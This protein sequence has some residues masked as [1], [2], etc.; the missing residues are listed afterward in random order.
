MRITPQEIQSRLIATRPE[1]DCLATKMSEHIEGELLVK[2]PEEGDVA[3][4][5]QDY[6]ATAVETIRFEGEMAKSFDGKLVR[7]RLPDGISTAQGIALLE[8]DPRVIYAD[9]NDVVSAQATPNDL[10]PSLWG[11]KKIEAEAAWDTV[12]GSRNGPIVA[13]IDSGIDA[14]HADLKANL[15]TNPREVADG[16][17][18]DDND[19]VD[20]LHGYNA[21][22]GSGDPDDDNHHGTH[23]SGTIAGVGNNGI[24][25]VG[26]NWEGQ[27]LAGKFLGANGKGSTANAVKAIGY[28]TAKGARIQSHSWGSGGGWGNRALEDVMRSSPSLHICAA[29]N[30][31]KDTDYSPQYPSAFDLDNV[32]AVAATDWNDNLAD[33]SNFGAASV[34][35]AAPGVG[36]KST[37]PG[38]GYESMSGTSMAT[39]HVSGVAALIATAIPG[40]TNDQLKNRLLSSVDVLPQLGGACVSGGRLNA[41]KAVETDRVAPGSLTRFGATARPTGE[42]SLGWVATGDDGNTGRAS[43][44]ELKSSGS[45]IDD[46]NFARASVMRTGLPLEAGQ[47][48]SRSSLAFPDSNDRTM[49]FGLKAVDN[50]GNRSPLARASVVIP[51][52]RV[53]FDDDMDGFS[54]KWSGEG[55]GRVSLEGRGKV[56]TDS[57]SGEYENGANRSLVS[58]SINLAGVQ[59]AAV[60][61]DYK[62]DLE[63]RFDKV[64][65]EVS[66]DGQNWSSLQE[67]TGKKMWERARVDLSAYDGQTIQLRFRLTTDNAVTKDG[68]YLDRVVVAG[69][70]K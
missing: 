13:V 27:I 26:V 44:Y 60:T 46:G 20:D 56:W 68:F 63:Q 22:N 7:M 45:P 5:S 51:G 9:A 35:L 11:L 6:G 41:R 24:G 16:R 10:D 1:A 32:V 54:N 36:I 38:G 12:K 15:W 31:G 14:N 34:D 58:P 28:A 62:H 61:F 8:K 53:A 52:T 67:F 4:L 3:E 23:C 33:F 37:V 47:T 19:I 66:G 2:L 49:H 21:I 64:T 40:I 69:A 18:N 70:H 55:W 25:V 43:L 42:V 17:D 50:V 59:G 30:D 29:G 39:P 48:E 57:P 65:L